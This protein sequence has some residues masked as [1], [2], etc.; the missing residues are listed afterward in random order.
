[1]W[2]TYQIGKRLFGESVGLLG[3]LLILTS[4]FFLMNTGSLLSHPLG[5]VLSAT[6]VMGWLDAFTARPPAPLAASLQP[7]HRSAC[8][9]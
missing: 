4:P 2:L 5:L 7:G 1:V 8:W 6:F 9:C 3:A